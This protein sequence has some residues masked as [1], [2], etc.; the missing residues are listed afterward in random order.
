MKT[1]KE[2]LGEKDMTAISSWKKKLKKMKGLTKQQI[3]MLSQLPTPVVTQ[4]INQIGMVV[5]SNDVE[6]STKAY[7]DTIR[8]IARDRQLKNISKKDKQTLLKIADLLAKANENVDEASLVMQ[9]MEIVRSILD[10]IE[11]DFQKLSLKGKMEAGWPRLQMLA[12]MAGYGVT[13][14]KQAK[15]R[16]FRYD[17]KKR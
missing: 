6:E 11:D 3:Q 10:K 8:K 15:N 2:H 1:F 9:D 17:L 4:L 5:S 7:G 13:K 12:K 14:A 16:T